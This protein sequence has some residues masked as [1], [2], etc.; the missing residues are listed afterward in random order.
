M[1]NSV[2]A[3]IAVLSMLL[4]AI[5]VVIAVLALDRGEQDQAFPSPTP[6]PTTPA[7]SP[8]PEESPT[9]S[10]ESPTTPEPSQPPSTAPVPT[11]ASPEPSSAPPEE[12]TGEPVAEEGPEQTFLGEGLASF[13]SFSAELLP[14]DAVPEPE[15]IR[16]RTGFNVEVCVLQSVG[17]DP[18]GTRV[19]LEPWTMESSAGEVRRPVTG[20]YSP[21]FGPEVFLDVGECASGWLTFDNFDDQDIDYSRL[22]YANGLGERAIWNFH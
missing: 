15:P 6:S 12:P 20:G 4:L 17:S 19:S 14:W 16:G 18:S 2:K 9:T 11:S 10:E 3:G 13:E 5:I 1:S 22:V 8:T 7:P 21:A